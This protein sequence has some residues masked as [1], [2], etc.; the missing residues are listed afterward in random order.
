MEP[1]R[2]EPQRAPPPGAEP[3]PK[4]FRIVKLEERIAPSKGGNGTNNTCACGT[5][6]VPTCPGAGSD[7]CFCVTGTA[8]CDTTY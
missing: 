7:T 6:N 5:V 8:F 2:E 4:R 1:H 3:K